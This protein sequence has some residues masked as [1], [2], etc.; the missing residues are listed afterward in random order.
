MAIKKDMVRY[1]SYINAILYRNGCG[2]LCKILAECMRKNLQHTSLV[3]YKGGWRKGNPSWIQRNLEHFTLIRTIAIKTSKVPNLSKRANRD[4]SLYP[5]W[6]LVAVW[7]S[8]EA[9][10]QG[11]ALSQHHDN[12]S[13]L[14]PSFRDRIKIQAKH[15]GSNNR[16]MTSCQP[17][18]VQHL[19][20]HKIYTALRKKTIWLLPMISSV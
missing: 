11:L 14:S 13:I 4:R 7:V 16:E 6:I 9:I 18:L 19:C 5:W 10:L 1:R 20:Y 15:K 12:N 8:M 3:H 2:Y 17:S